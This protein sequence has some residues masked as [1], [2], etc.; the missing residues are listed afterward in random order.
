MAAATAVAAVLFV[1]IDLL[2]TLDRYLRIKPPLLYVVEHF[3]YR[4]PAALHDGLPVIVLV[5]T[6]FL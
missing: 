4:L 1:V 5:A 3:A 6:I 2:Q